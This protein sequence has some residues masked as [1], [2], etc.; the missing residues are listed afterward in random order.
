MA[1]LQQRLNA[2]LAAKESADAI[3]AYDTLCSQLRDS[4]PT[5][6]E[7]R[8]AAVESGVSIPFDAVSRQ[9]GLTPIEE[10][11][12][13]VC[14]APH[15]SATNAHLLM[16]AQGNV[17]KAYLEV[18]FV[19]ELTLPATNLLTA[20][21]WC[22]SDSTLVRDG[23][24]VV[25][26]PPEGAAPVSLLSHSVYSPHYVAAAVSG[27]PDIDKKLSDFCDIRF[28]KIELFD[29]VLAEET[30]A[31][32][33][34]FVR[35]F[36]RRNAPMQLGERSWTLLIS[37]PRRSGKTTL[38]RAITHSFGR[39]IFEVH[40]ERLER[41]AEAVTMLRLAARNAQ[42]LGAVLLLVQPEHLLSV[43]PSSLGTLLGLV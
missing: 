32:V 38:A 5:G 17:L 37:G 3:A 9:F 4:R 27:V 34:D 43:D 25:E 22:D 42:F 23:L 18:G 2:F 24:I 1:R 41:R 13:M 33:E 35:G 36:Y 28:P 40:L 7:R 6:I 29:V 31:Q 8:R 30:R 20:R 39:P 15:L 26:R 12:L 21:R 19:A 11:L 14:L 16:C 10:E